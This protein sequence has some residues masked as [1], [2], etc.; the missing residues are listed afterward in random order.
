MSLT[1]ALEPIAPAWEDFIALARIHWEGTKSYHR[2]E[3]FAPALARYQPCN[4]SGFLQFCTARSDGALVGY[5]LFYVTNSMHSQ[6]RMA[7]ED[8]FFLHPDYRR[9]RNALRML[10]Y[11]EA[12]CREF[13]AE[14]LLCSCEADNTSGIQR[15]LQFLD[16]SP[17]IMQYSKRLLSPRA[18]SAAAIPSEVA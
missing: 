10:Q 18:D 17:V 3:P 6:K 14:E 9:G 5:L 13:G 4:E 7:V 12:R 15:L 11:V 8:T 16:Y 1:F 2:H